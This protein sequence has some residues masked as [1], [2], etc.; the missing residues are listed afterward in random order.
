MK[1]EFVFRLVLAL[2]IFFLVYQFA[3]KP[4]LGNNTAGNESKG[5]DTL[6]KS[7]STGDEYDVIVF[8]EEPDGIAA[9]VMAARLGARTLL[10][11]QHDNLGGVISRCLLTDMEF[12][13]GADNKLLNGGFL[14]E[15][16]M[17]LGRKFSPHDY[18]MTI[19]NM[20]KDEK[21]LEVRYNIRLDPPSM[22]EY[23]LETL[24]L[25]E[26][27][28][29]AAVRGRIFIDATD[30][31]ELLAACK[32]SF[33]TGSEDL[34]LKDS[35]MPL[36]LN[37]EMTGADKSKA[38]S[39]MK[40]T[41]SGLY[42]KLAK[43]KPVNIDTRIGDFYIQN[44]D[45]KDTLIVQGLQLAN[46][47][48]MDP[49]RVKSAYGAAVKEAKNFA[50]FL[51]KTF[52]ELKGWEFKRPAGELYIREGRHFKGLYTLGVNEIL[53]NSIPDKTIAMGSLPI[54][55]GKLA[56]QSS[57]YAG[58]PVQYGIPIGCLITPQVDNLLMTGAKI[59][60]SS[61]AASSAGTLG[62]SAATGASAGIVSVYCLMNGQEPADI[63]REKNIEKITSFRGFMNKQGIYLP[64]KEIKNK[65]T[66]N[67][68]YPALRELLSLGL[69]SGGLSNNYNFDR[70]AVQADLAILLLNG[71]Y[72]MSSDK[73]S[74]ALDLRIRPY[75]SKEELTKENT[76]ELLE[77][78]YDLPD[79][80]KTSYEKVCRLGYIN[81]IMQLELKNKKVL[82]MDDVFYLAAHNIKTFTGKD[83]KD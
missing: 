35:Y 19:N 67:W 74:L 24:N 1:K 70:K 81:D 12:P 55:I 61:L 58:D 34:N 44:I 56:G 49:M 69:V 20:V 52:E 38:E 71:I 9:A 78:L 43:Y 30:N 46:V 10:L 5:R 3:L 8:G 4:M 18:E 25:K 32:V 27:D 57:V 48:V 76:A 42:R 80:G 23:R 6:Y 26:N 29:A 47:N 17:K 15:L 77:A 60:Y 79:K 13:F 75:F 72:R 82:T 40:E 83:I 14:S 21:N 59:S 11:S 62:T 53:E 45:E 51:S 65:N 31:G 33:T 16:Y 50:F 66:S 63:E 7:E 64:D 2:A 39:L 37:F 54:H 41:D 22:R 73:Y 36:S 28:K 68:S